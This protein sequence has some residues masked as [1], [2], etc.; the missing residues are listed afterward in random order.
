MLGGDA[1]AVVLGSPGRCFRQHHVD[2]IVSV[3]R[4]ETRALRRIDYVIRRRD[5]TAEP[6]P[7]GIPLTPKRRDEVSHEF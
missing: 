7:V 5:Q 6:S 1:I 2:D 4:R 3:E